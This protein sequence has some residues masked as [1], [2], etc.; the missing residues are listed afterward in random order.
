II[1]V[2]CSGGRCES[3]ANPNPLVPL[4]SHASNS[5]PFHAANRDY[6]RWMGIALWI[7][8]GALASLIA[9]RIRPMRPRWWWLEPAL[10][11]AVA[12]LLGTLATALD[13]GGW[14]EPDWRA[15]I[16]VFAGSFAA[17]AGSRIIRTTR[18]SSSASDATAADRP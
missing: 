14:S 16:F 2:S 18:L 3:H 10:S 13:F 17:I 8:A 7:G 11:L 6:H 5:E 15:G 9:W 4:P 1:E 12:L